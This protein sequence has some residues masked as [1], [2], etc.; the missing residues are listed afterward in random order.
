M[1][2]QKIDH[3]YYINLDK[4]TDRDIHTRNQVLPFFDLQEGEFSRFSAIDTSSEPTLPLRSV[5]CAMSHLSIFKD[6]IEKEYK[7]IFVFEDD[8]IPIIQSDEMVSNWNY[9]INNFPSFNICQIAYNDIEK[10]KPL[11]DSNIVYTSSNIQTTSAYIIKVEFAKKIFKTISDSIECLK[12]NQDPNIHAI[13]QCWKKFQS[14]DH[15][16]YLLKRSGVQAC[17]YSD[18]EGKLVSYGC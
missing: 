12:L 18:I 13:D 7:T 6:A 15:Q 17:D 9:F 5:G 1:N 10:A 3:S 4:R 14:L 8:F 2:L 11:N 16:W